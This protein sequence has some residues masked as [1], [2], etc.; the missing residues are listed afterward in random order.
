MSWWEGGQFV[1]HVLQWKTNVPDF[2]ASSNSSWLNVTVWL[3]S[4]GQTISKSMRLLTESP[5]P[6][7]LQGDALQGDALQKPM[8]YEAAKQKSY[9]SDIRASHVS[10]LNPRIG[11]RNFRM[12]RRTEY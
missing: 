11:A 1:S 9:R 10:Y 4:F 7:A 3:W 8:R 6:Y 5:A 12:P 2:N